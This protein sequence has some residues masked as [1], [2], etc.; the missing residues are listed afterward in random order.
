MFLIEFTGHL[1]QYIDC[2]LPGSGI[3]LKVLQPLYSRSGP[4]ANGGKPATLSF[5]ARTL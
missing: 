1:S 4:S 3:L 2:M 5:A